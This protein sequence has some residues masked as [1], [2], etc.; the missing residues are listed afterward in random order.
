MKTNRES[1]AE[2]DEG[3]NPVQRRHSRI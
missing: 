3:T 2:E 1:N